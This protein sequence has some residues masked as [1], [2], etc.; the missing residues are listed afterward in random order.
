MKRHLISEKLD[1]FHAA[2]KRWA[3]FSK[4]QKK[5][6]A[7]VSLI[8]G[9]LM[10]LAA[11]GAHLMFRVQPVISFAYAWAIQTVLL[12]VAMT[13]LELSSRKTTNGRG[14]K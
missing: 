10:L 7:L 12:V 13:V 1:L 6:I 2:V 5:T 9:L 8:S 14:D 11:Y 4:G 3:A